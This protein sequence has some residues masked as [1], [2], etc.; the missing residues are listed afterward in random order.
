MVL[1]ALRL[2]CTITAV[3]LLDASMLPSSTEGHNL[4]VFIEQKLVRLLPNPK[5][6]RGKVGSL[7]SLLLFP[8]CL[9]DFGGFCSWFFLFVCFKESFFQ[10]CNSCGLR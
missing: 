5:I 10:I 2:E 4:L 6:Y 9:F 1:S 3:E 7:C 8:F